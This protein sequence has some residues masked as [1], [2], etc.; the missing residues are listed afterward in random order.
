MTTNEKL[1]AVRKSKKLS[2]EYVGFAVH[3]DASEISRYETGKVEPS[4]PTL[5][6]LAKVY[7]VDVNDLLGSEHEYMIVPKVACDEQAIVNKLYLEL[8]KSKNLIEIRQVFNEQLPKIIQLQK[9]NNE[10]IEYIKNNW[11]LEWEKLG[12]NL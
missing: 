4:I 12:I 6:K 8:H 11:P 1:L 9:T 5:Q 7:K 3:K 10:R 2:Q